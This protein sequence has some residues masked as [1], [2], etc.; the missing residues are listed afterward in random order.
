M[1][2]VGSFEKVQTSGPILRGVFLA[3]ARRT[4]GMIGRLGLEK[5]IVFTGGVARNAGVVDAMRQIIGMEIRVP[6]EPEFT[7]ALGAAILAGRG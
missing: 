1:R 6:L 3:V 4:R 2:E 5:E 7:G